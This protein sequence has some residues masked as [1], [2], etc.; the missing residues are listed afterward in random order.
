MKNFIL[1]YLFILLFVS[2]VK[3]QS[4]NCSTATSINLSSGSACANGTS[5]GAITD[6][7]L[8]STCNSSPVNIVWYTYIANGSNN[9][10][11]I[12]PGTLTNAQI[13]IYTG[14]CPSS[15]SGQLQTCNTVVGNATLTSIWGMTLGEQVWVGV[16][17]NGGTDG[18]FQLC[19]NSTPPAAGVGNT[20]A[21]SIPIC[22]TTFSHPVMAVNASGQVSSCFGSAPQ[23]DIWIAFTITKAGTLAWTGTPVTGATEFDWTLWDITAGCPGTSVCCNY[24]FASGS[25]SGFGMQNS[26]GNVPCGTSASTGDPAQEFSPTKAVTCGKTYAIQIS[27]YSNTNKGFTL[28]FTSST[29]LINSTSSFTPSPSLICGTTLTASIT[30]ASTGD[31][32]AVWDYGDGSATY[33]GIAPPNHTYSTPGTY[34]IT[35]S[36]GGVCPSTATQFIQLLAPLAVTAS[37]TS[38]S[39]SG[40]CAGTA[41]VSSVSGG[42]GI[43]TYSW[44]TGNTTNNISSLCPGTYSVTVSNAKCGTSITKTVSIAAPSALTLTPT[45]TNANCGSSNGNVSVS[46]SGG[47][48]PYTYAINGGAFTASTSYSGLASGTYTMDVKDH[49][50]CQASVTV[51]VGTNP[52]ATVTVTSTTICP[53]ATGT[54]TASGATTYSWTSGLSATTGS[55]VTGSPGATTS[56]TVIGT[57]GTCTNSA[58]ATITLYTPPTLTVTSASICNGAG[59]ATLGVS[60]AST[61]TWS[62]GGITGSHSTAPSDNPGGTTIYTVNGTDAH[63]CTATATG[64][65]NVISTPTI[66]VNSGPICKGQTTLSLTANSN[67]TS[68]AWSPATG[69]SA[70]T[71]STVVASPTSTQSYTI[72]GTAGTCTVSTTAT[73]TVNNPP[74][75]TTTSS[76]ICIGQ[77]TGTVT[78][79]GA[80]TYT[81]T[82]GGISGNTTTNPTDNPVS[83]TPYIV[84][85]IDVNTCTATA[86]A[87]ITVNPLPTVT[88]NST[89]I[90]LGQ[91]TATLTASGASTYSWTAGLSATT[92]AIVTGSPAG[93]TPYTVTGTDAKGCINT[94]VATINVISNPTITVANGA[95]CVGQQSVTLTANSNAASFVWSPATGLSAT[96]GSMVTAN[97][98]T[99]GPNTYTVVGTAGSC[100]VSTTATVTV[101]ILPVATP[102]VTHMP[103]ETEEPLNLTSTVA[104]AGTYTYSWSGPNSFISSVQ[105]PSITTFS[106]VTQAVAG[107]YTILVTDINNCHNTAT[108]TVVVN[109][110]PIITATG[111]TV[112]VG[113]TINLTSN[114]A[115][116]G[117]YSWGETS[118]TYTYTS[119]S[120]NPTILNAT[121][122]MTGIYN[123]VGRDGK[124][125]YS[126][127]AVQVQVNPL[128]I[129]TATS[130]TMCVGQQTAT[131][132]ASSS[133]PGTTYSWTPV[134]ALSATTGSVVVANPS[135]AGTYTYLVTGT[136]A[137]TCVG[138]FSTSVL[139]NPTPTI[140]V[141]SYTICIGQQTA[142]LTA[143]STNT[144]TTY[145]WLPATG[146][147]STTT[148]VVTG[149]PTVSTNY[150][151]TGTDGNGCIGVGNAS[152]L[153][154]ILPTIT[155]TSGTI[156]TGQTT[157]LTASGGVTFTWTPTTG[158]SSANGSP[159]VAN[160]TVTTTSQNYT[161]TVKG[162]DGNGCI[163][164]TSSQVLVYPLPVVTATRDSICMGQQVAV[165]HASGA[166]TYTWTPSNT[167]S[168]STG[169]TVNGSP[170]TAGENDYTVTATDIHRCVNTATTSIWVN[171]LPTVTI[172]TVSPECVPFCTTITAV[173]M[174]AGTY[175]YSWNLGNGQ[176]TVSPNFTVA[177]CYSVAGTY[178]VNLLLTDVNG[179]T[180]I[181]SVAVPA[182]SIPI[183]AF[184]YGQQPVSI[185]APDVVFTNESTYGLPYY[186]WNFGD[187]YTGSS[188]DT[189]SVSNPSHTYAEVGTYSVTLTVSTFNGCSATV[190]NTVIINEDYVLYVPNAFSPNADGKNETFK[191]VGEGIKDYQLYVFD[192][193]GL[194]IFYSDDINKGWDGKIQGGSELVQEDIYVWKIQTTD[195]KKKTR[196]LNGTVTLLK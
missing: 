61:Y 153:V 10:F 183:A 152:I 113:Q 133:N 159:M 27:N 129:I 88:V 26:A 151:I 137:N 166:S 104:P 139:V 142:T 16:A 122:A 32:A 135:P 68:F 24:N 80:N 150:T 188:H 60:G 76:T 157:T 55:A 115:G 90:C 98:T 25:S 31:C 146:L 124:G 51:T 11:T 49:N 95:M 143:S 181:T 155:A 40:S 5:A 17:S 174:A 2:E 50:N 175:T 28:D 134:T 106:D 108:V 110:K 187:L 149:T 74:T 69:L 147:S 42:D 8:Y 45:P 47:T 73:V 4:T 140:T 36:I 160:P 41:S 173:P 125:C 107:T 196:N 109:P 23:R 33:T 3:S 154:N 148:T 30:N 53:G 131:L 167:L 172:N 145:S 136:D 186:S 83:T 119:G 94:A 97:P 46:A 37:S 112:C 163:D 170:T 96:T 79:G 85:A 64:T 43:Y 57:T 180:D 116:G 176:T 82:G 191:A 66:S 7:V 1:F 158:L 12:T 70:T 13:I 48:S 39:C 117:N 164:S 120:Q 54:L 132:T 177:A 101:Y 21:Q 29:C 65:I 81:W 58:V 171:T 141:N 102:S 156:C 126:G 35:E 92:G 114:G 15:P 185:L 189:S 72:V 38:V 9:S 87:T 144:L 127:T 20:C 22:S 123:V 179:C 99:V 161:Y 162:T 165:L 52:A 63:T 121:T 128:P 138:T 67:A 111:A 6:N 190:V 75:L 86:T 169:A 194:L 100:T 91:Q 103:C 193:W 192:R 178:A 14:G 130:G 89:T 78:V 93:T 44:N 18:T 34:A 182:L 56:Y 77:Q 105:N 62:G 184:D 19:I 59:P 71:G 195:F 118:P 168:S 84:N